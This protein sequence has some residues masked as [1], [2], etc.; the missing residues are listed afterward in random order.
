MQCG[1]LSSIEHPTGALECFEWEANKARIE[2]RISL[3]NSSVFQV[4]DELDGKD[5]L[6]VLGGLRIKELKVIDG[7]KQR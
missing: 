5:G 4:K 2:E 6:Y 3:D 7:E 1:M